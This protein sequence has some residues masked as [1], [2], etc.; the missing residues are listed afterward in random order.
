MQPRLLYS[1]VIGSL[2]LSILSGCGR[3]APT[4]VVN[5]PAVE[6]SLASTARAFAKQTELANPY[7]A[8]P[9][10]TATETPTPTPR[11]SVNGTM[12]VMDEDGSALFTDYT[13]G[14]QMVIPAGW[15]PLR[16]NEQEYYQAFT[17]EIAASN[18]AIGQRLT[19]IQDADLNNFR[20]DAIDVRE[21]HTINGILSDIYINFY[22][23][24]ARSLEQ[25]AQAEGK[26]KSAF[27]NY[28]FLNRGYPKTSDGTRTLVIDRTWTQDQTRKI[29]QR[30]VFFSLPTGVLV[31]NLYSH[32]D[33]K[34]TVL[35]DFDQVVNSVT[36]LNP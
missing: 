8:T 6:T 18:P 20:L 9:T 19:Q 14:I 2:F 28:L 11:I 17:S 1:I 35:P 34:D 16:V 7:T 10:P 26:K 4:P 15:L 25:V 33:I 13:A 32:K 29:F 21:G 3:S 12:L 22:S 23:G 5:P 31:L 24:D 27:K 30:S 36:A